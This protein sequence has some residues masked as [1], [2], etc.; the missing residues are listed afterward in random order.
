MFIVRD[1]SESVHSFRSAMLNRA[2]F[3][4]LDQNACFFF[5]LSYDRH[6]TP[7]GVH[8]ARFVRDL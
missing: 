5:D 8:G 1:H 3:F 7:K 2:I 4:Q 6:R